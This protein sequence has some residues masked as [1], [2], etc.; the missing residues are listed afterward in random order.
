[1][2]TPIW[3]GQSRHRWARVA[4][5]PAGLSR[6]ARGEG[7]QPAATLDQAASAPRP[8]LGRRSGEAPAGGLALAASFCH[9]FSPPGHVDTGVCPERDRHFLSNCVVGASLEEITEEEEEEDESKSAVPEASAAKLKEGT[10]QIVGTL[11]NPKSTRPDFAVETYSTTSREDLL[12][13]L[14]ECDVI[15]YNITESAQQAEEAIWAV[16]ALNEEVSHFEKRKVFI[17][18]STVMTWA[19]SKPLDPEDSE[20][21]FTEEDYRRRRPHP[22]FLDHINAEKLVLKFGKNVKKFA[23]YVVAAGLQ[24]GGEGGI[25]HTFFKMAW[26]GEVPALPVFG[27][28][29][30]V[31]PAI[32]V[33]DLAGVIQNIIDHVPKPHYLV[34]VDESGHTLEDIIKCISKT[35]GPGKIQKLPKENASLIKDLTQHGLDHLLVNLRMEALFVKENFNIRWAAQAGFVENVSSVLR[36]YKETRGL[37]VTMTRSYDTCSVCK[38]S[39]LLV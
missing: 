1:M 7:A 36:E 24:Y 13:R 8:P 27:D 12:R 14:L 9:R 5:T 34:A 25:L 31:I 22:N 6:I 39:Q 18:L 4:P 16:S 32:H 30:N 2:D 20:V 38:R 23:T 19:R 26:L 3:G 35:T 15:V 33:L 28:G 37:L 10:F 29:T 11:A 17:L 21:P